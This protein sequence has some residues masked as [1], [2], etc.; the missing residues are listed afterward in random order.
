MELY[1]HSHI[2]PQGVHAD[3][4][5]YTFTSFYSQQEC[6]TMVWSVIPDAIR[7]DRWRCTIHDT[8]LS[9]PSGINHLVA[10]FRLAAW[11]VTVNAVQ[12]TVNSVQVTVNSV[13]V[14]V[15]TVQVTVNSVQVT[16]NSVQ[17]T[18]NTVQVTVNSV[19]L[20]QLGSGNSQLGS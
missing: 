13:Q 5:T 7:L 14:T 10:S 16:V 2:R 18:V 19:Q 8:A 17:V 11:P 15:N 4:F 12:I 1:L 20:S 9:T 3:K 6:P